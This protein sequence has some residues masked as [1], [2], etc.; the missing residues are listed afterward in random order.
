MGLSPHNNFTGGSPLR[1]NILSKVIA[2]FIAILSTNV[3]AAGAGNTGGG[4]YNL[5]IIASRTKSADMTGTNGHALF[6]GM[7]KT[8][9]IL[10]QEGDFNVIDRNGTDGSASFSL[11]SPDP[12]NSGTTGY[13]VFARMVGKPGSKIDMATCAYDAAG[14]LF[15]S[16]EVL[17]MSRIAGTSRFQNVSQNL[18]YVYADIDADGVED[19]VPLF[20]SALQDYFWSVD[21]QGRAHAQLRFCPVAT[22][23]R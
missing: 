6:I 15:C 20:G 2:T 18:L 13:S 23:V 4:C 8:T 22:T 19:R 14:E 17:S 12:T 10:L 5:Q 16:Q 3:F 21:A 11:P 1:N 7:D 9:K